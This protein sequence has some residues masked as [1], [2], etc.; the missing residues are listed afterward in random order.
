VLEIHK[1]RQ[2]PDVAV[3][4]CAAAAYLG[5]LDPKAGVKPA[6]LP[7][8]DAKAVRL[9]LAPLAAISGGQQRRRAFERRGSLRASFE[10]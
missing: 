10:D 8:A 3:R 6:G 7:P 2:A 9:V 5:A 1:Q 4:A